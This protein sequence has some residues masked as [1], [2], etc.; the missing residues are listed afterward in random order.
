MSK[1][2]KSA[3]AVSLFILLAIIPGCPTENASDRPILLYE[4]KRIITEWKLGKIN[5][6]DAAFE[7]IA[8]NA[9]NNQT[10]RIALGKDQTQEERI[11]NAS[12]FNYRTGVT[13]ILE[14]KDKERVISNNGDGYLYNIQGGY[15]FVLGENITLK[16]GGVFV[17]ARQVFEM[18]DGSKI[19]GAVC[20]VIV[21][22]GNF[23]MN[24]GEITNNGFYDN[25]QEAGGVIVKAGGRFEMNGGIISGN[26][27][28]NS[29]GVFIE[30]NNYL[31]MG[32]FK[33]TRGIITGY[34]DD[35]VNG[36]RIVDSNGQTDE[37]GK[38]HAAYFY[39]SRYLNNTVNE[40]H[41]IYDS[42]GSFEGW[43][44]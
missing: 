7:W 25:L 34:G 2:K 5:T 22:R 35:P 9:V 44:D 28:K 36:N 26:V 40:N 38:G 29:G 30:H 27:G 12:S 18:R 19:T 21:G 8:G 39:Q 14:G 20:G 41:Y 4:G 1:L 16:G 37:S 23:T 32:S 10:Y 33:K 11:I 42:A 13:L 43:A 6:L 15:L 24:G 3:Y 31:D 17:D